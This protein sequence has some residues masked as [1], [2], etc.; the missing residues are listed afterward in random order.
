MVEKAYKTRSRIID[1]STVQALF[2]WL[3]YFI[4]CSNY[5]RVRLANLELDLKLYILKFTSFEIH[6]SKTYFAVDHTLIEIVL[7]HGFQLTK[8]V[9]KSENGFC[10]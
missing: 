7:R 6:L 9:G 10:V 4:A 2:F 1:L 8:S 3:T 5:G